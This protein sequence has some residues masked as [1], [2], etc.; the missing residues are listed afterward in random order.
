MKITERIYI[1][2]GANYV[3]SHNFD[4]NVYLIDLKSELVM[5]DTGAGVNVDAIIRNIKKDGLD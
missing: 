5:I 3:L 1:V 2:R 4:C